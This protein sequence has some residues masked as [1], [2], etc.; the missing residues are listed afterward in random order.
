MSGASLSG[1]SLFLD[2]TSLLMHLAVW[3]SSRQEWLFKIEAPQTSQ[4]FHSAMMIPML[5]EAF[6]QNH[7]SPQDIQALILHEGPGSFTGIRTGLVTGRI[8]AQ[9]LHCPVYTINAFEVMAP[10]QQP[11]L[12][13]L[14]ALRGNAYCAVLTLSEEDVMYKLEPCILPIETALEH[15]QKQVQQVIACDSLAS[16]LPDILNQEPPAVLDR[17]LWLV[18]HH[19]KRL[20]KPWQEIKPLYLQEPNITQR[21]PQPGRLV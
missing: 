2:T 1:L 16:K 12:V 11:C 8:L 10:L 19:A 4:R 20:Q 7:I 13:M 21:K 14:D 15:W 3:D 18:Q 9:F 6:Q 5:N 17:M